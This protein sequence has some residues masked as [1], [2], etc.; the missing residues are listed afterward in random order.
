M[1]RNLE[2]QIAALDTVEGR[3]G[4][5]TI[6]LW[7]GYK[8]QAFL[9]RTIALVQ[10]PTTGL[11]I[12]A[13]LVMFFFADTVIEVPPKPHPGYYSVKEL[14][15]SAFTNVAQEV[16]NL[17]ASYQPDR[18]DLQYHTARKYLWEPALSQVQ[19][20]MNDEIPTV[21][22]L[23]RS[24]LFL[25]IPGLTRVQRDTENDLVE[26][27]LFGTRHKLLAASPIESDDLVYEVQMKTIPR[28]VSNEYGIVV[29]GIKLR[30][31]DK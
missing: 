21:K 8:E 7:E 26:V 13:A 5:D 2:K 9:W 10:I 20:F 16:V 24:Q 18:I 3:A 12:L 23:R 27:S 30:A 15:D 22:N 25:I 29:T 4:S 28:N 31:R 17:L 19:K 1:A 14:P 11:A 6:R